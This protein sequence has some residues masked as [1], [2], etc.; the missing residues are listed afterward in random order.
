MAIV[1]NH[2]AAELVD[3]LVDNLA[4]LGMVSH[5]MAGA[6]VLD[7]GIGAPGGMSAGLAL[8]RVCLADLATV[9]LVPGEQAGWRGPWVTIRTDRPVLACLGSQYA[10]M[11]VAVGKYFAMGSGPMRARLGSEPILKK[12]GIHET[13]DVAVGVL[14]TGKLP[15]AEVILHLA[16]KLGLEPDRITLLVAPTTSI[17]GMVQVVARSLETALHQMHEAGFP[18]ECVVSG[19]GCAP[20][21]APCPDTIGAIGR[22]NDAILYGGRV[23][24]FVSTRPG[25]EGLIDELGPKTTS[26][27]SPAH[28]QPFAEIFKAAGGDFYKID[29]RLF[30]PAELVL[31]DLTTGRSRVFGETRTDLLRR[32]FGA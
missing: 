32:S 30:A 23:E 28:G 24:L 15:T 19:M 18:L 1:L 2:R 26:S 31:H 3:S 17:A 6:R 7:A 11:Q 12:L 25:Q 22:S 14:E 8:A 4:N 29:P 10:G 27:A 5:T 13:T 21:P 9:D 16:G 20:L